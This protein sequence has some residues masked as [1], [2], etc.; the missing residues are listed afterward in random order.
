MEIL[1]KPKRHANYSIISGGNTRLG[2]TRSLYEASDNA[3]H[4]LN[5][6]SSILG[7]SPYLLPS[8]I[9]NTIYAFVLNPETI[10][11]SVFTPETIQVYVLCSLD[12]PRLSLILVLFPSP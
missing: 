9:G 12:Y 10:H 7:R 4:S 1:T 2:L 5:F 8:S 11:V 3:M 6:S